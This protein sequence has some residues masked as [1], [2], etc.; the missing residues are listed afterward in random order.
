M[1]LR[2]ERGASQLIDRQ[3]VRSKDSPLDGQTDRPDDGSPYLPTGLRIKVPA[4]GAYRRTARP[5][6]GPSNG[7][8]DRPSNGSIDRY[9]NLMDKGHTDELLGVRVKSFLQPVP[10]TFMSQKNGCPNETR[11]CE[12]I[13]TEPEYRMSSKIIILRA[14]SEKSAS[15]PVAI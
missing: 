15:C 7:S 10:A 1:R 12:P 14:K 8:I 3:T 9:T 13:T 2:H 11:F 5:A 6:E 4:E